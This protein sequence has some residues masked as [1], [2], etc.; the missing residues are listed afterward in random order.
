VR[1]RL[2]AV[3]KPLAKNDVLE[4]EVSEDI[5]LE[6]LTKLVA[7]VGGEKLAARLLDP[8]DGSL[9]PDIMVL[10]N[11]VDINLLDG[12][13]TKLKD[14]D[15]VI[16]LPTVHGGSISFHSP[17]WDELYFKVVKLADLIESSGFKPDVI[18]G[19]ARGGWV[20]ARLLSDLLDNPNVASVKVEFYRDI[21]KTAEEPV[22][23]QPLSTPVSG[24]KVLIVDDVA[25]TGKSL[26]LV[27]KHVQERGAREV[28]VATVYYK[29]WSIVKPD[30][31]VDETT[32]WIIFPHEIK[33]TMTKLLERWLKE[34]LSLEEAKLKL[35]STGIQ[36]KALEALLPKVLRN[37]GLK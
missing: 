27:K 23:S 13:R 16:F 26:D 8:I 24:L 19:V 14:G 32:T 30:Y 11:G 6:E 35:R 7:K 21:A 22:I 17:W 37:L 31:Y 4:L 15:E 25:D 34:G 5:N 10:I 33:E 1:I 9:Q 3:L 2:L 20:I 18:V 12:L 29:P 28:K 36:P